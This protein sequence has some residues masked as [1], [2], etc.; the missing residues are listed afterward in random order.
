MG[1]ISI[2]EDTAFRYPGLTIHH[3]DPERGTAMVDKEEFEEVRRNDPELI[4]HRRKQKNVTRVKELLK[5]R[6][7]V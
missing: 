2:P 5:K 4:E 6:T 3:H 7:V 1:L